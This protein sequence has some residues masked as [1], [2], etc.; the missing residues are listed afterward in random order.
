MSTPDWDNAKK[1]YYERYG[2]ALSSIVERLFTA[3]D[4]L[5]E[6]TEKYKLRF[7]DIELAYAKKCG[8]IEAIIDVLKTPNLGDTGAIVQIGEILNFDFS[9]LEV[10]DDK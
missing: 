2:I 10:K 9:Q 3:G 1:R 6:D 5:R 7:R 8:T 4:K